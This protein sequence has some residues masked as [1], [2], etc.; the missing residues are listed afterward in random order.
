MP[1]RMIKGGKR[2]KKFRSKKGKGARRGRSKHTGKLQTAKIIE[3]VE[4]NDL[5]SN[6]VIHANFA[7]GQFERASALAPNFKFYKA[8]KVS[9]NLEPLYNVFQEGTT[10]AL[11]V[12]YLYTVMN[13]TQDAVGQVVGDLQAMGARPKKLVAKHTTTYRPNWCSPGLTTYSRS[14][15]APYFVTAVQNM[16]LKTQY[17]YLPCPNTNTGSVGTTSAMSPDWFPNSTI[18]PGEVSLPAQISLNQVVYNGH[19]YFIDQLVNAAA[20]IKVARLTCT[21]EWHFKDPH[22]TSSPRADAPPPL[23]C[24]TSFPI[25]CGSCFHVLITSSS[26]VLTFRTTDPHPLTVRS[27]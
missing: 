21:V 23:K 9:W 25:K 3:T 19:A 2:V 26:N 6:Q 18:A 22:F 12:P 8:A 1:F 5:T 10:S 16:G 13:R 17:G 11:S 7:I 14:M 15:T 20:D 24:G 27:D 4:F